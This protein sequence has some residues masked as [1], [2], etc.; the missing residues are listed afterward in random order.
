MEDKTWLRNI[1]L[2]YQNLVY[3]VAVSIIKDAQLAEDIM[4][5]V[6]VTLYFKYGTI[7]DRGSLK[8]WLIRT[9]V[10]RTLD[11]TR[12]LK[13]SVTLPDDYFERLEDTAW[14]D[15]TKEMTDQEQA[16]ALHHAMEKLPAE[17]KALVVLAYF[18]EMPLREIAATLDLALGTVKTR[19][20]RARLFLKKQLLQQ[21]LKANLSPEQGVSHDE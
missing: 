21:E 16:Q 6:F 7:R 12:K 2:E 17:L 8:P 4:Q 11:F 3:G 1:Y 18:L 15:P 13:R 9:T 10:N 20:R 5:E 14:A 19:L